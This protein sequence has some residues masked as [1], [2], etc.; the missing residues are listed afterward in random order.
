MWIMLAARIN[1]FRHCCKHVRHQSY[2]WVSWLSPCW[3][4]RPISCVHSTETTDCRCVAYERLFL[5]CIY[6]FQGGVIHRVLNMAVALVVMRAMLVPVPVPRATDC[7]SV[8]SM[9]GRCRSRIDRRQYLTSSV[10]DFLTCW[11]LPRH[12]TVQVPMFH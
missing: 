10:P 12:G 2:R 1:S 4:T 9:L 8:Y 3:H 11:R 5:A 6:G 7:R